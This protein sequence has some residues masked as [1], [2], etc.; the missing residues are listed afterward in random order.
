[1]PQ[2]FTN[3]KSTLVQV[4]AWCCQATSHYMS[5]CWPRSISPQC[6]TKPQWVK[7]ILAY[8][9]LSCSEEMLIYIC[10]FYHFSTEMKAQRFTNRYV[11]E[12]LHHERGRSPD[13]I[14]RGWWVNSLISRHISDKQWYFNAIYYNVFFFF[15]YI[16][17]IIFLIKSYCFQ[18]RC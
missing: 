9:V 5:H 16:F 4:M 8:S 6:I 3:G 11:P 17:Y 1:M 10:T 7:Y 2:K 15:I 14:I 13:G 12:C 18:N